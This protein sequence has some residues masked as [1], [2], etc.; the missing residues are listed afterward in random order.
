MIVRLIVPVKKGRVLMWSY[1]GKNYSCNP[2]A[3]TEYILAHHYEDYEIYW[4]FLPNKVP[5]ELP[6]GINSITFK[7]MKYIWVVNT[8]EYLVTNTRDYLSN[9]LWLKKKNQKYIMTWHSSMGIKCIEGDASIESLSQEYVKAAKFDS[10]QCDLILAGSRAR[11]EIIRRA[12]WY[13]GEVYEHGTPRNDILFNNTYKAEMNRKIREL[14]R[15]PDN[16]AIILYAPTFRKSRS[17]EFYTINWNKIIKRFE[18]KFNRT[19]YVLVKLHPNLLDEGLD[20]SSIVDYKNT[21]DATL[22]PDIQDLLVVADVLITDYSSSMFDFSYMKKMVFLYA[23][24]YDSYD[25]DTYFQLEKLP[26]LF[27]TNEKQLIDNIDVF[28][29]TD[30]QKHLNV[31]LEEEIGSYETGRANEMLVKWMREHSIK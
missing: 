31:F 7:N 17:L 13:S 2:R 15:I 25:R 4:A 1:Y 10:K 12:F 11:A 27:A 9:T 29:E 16:T 8:A 28:S 14:Y 18:E 30:Y 3:L 21:Y 6:L 5:K 19:C 26:F 20:T 23:N 24:D 22:Y